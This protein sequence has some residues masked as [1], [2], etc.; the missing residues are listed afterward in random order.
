MKPLYSIVFLLFVLTFLAGCKKDDDKEKE[1]T[2][3]AML[4]AK[5]WKIQNI[6]TNPAVPAGLPVDINAI[7]REALGDL[8]NSDIKFDANGTYVSTDR[9]TG[10]TSSDKW[11][12]GSNETQLIINSDGETYTFKIEQL[13]TSNL[14]LSLP[15]PVNFGG[16]PINLTVL[17][18][19]IPAS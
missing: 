8:S 14:N 4:T 15:Y 3:T 12:F 16:L 11:S 7:I 5:P 13:T 18:N 19:L 6:S 2:K 1:L 17:V 10:A 9:T